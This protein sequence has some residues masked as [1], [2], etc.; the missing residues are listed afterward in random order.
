MVAREGCSPRFTERYAKDFVSEQRLSQDGDHVLALGKLAGLLIQY[1]T[2]DPAG[3][4]FFD[5]FPSA[6]YNEAGARVFERSFVCPSASIQFFRHSRR[7]VVVDGCFLSGLLKGVLL[8]ATV[9][10]AANR[11]QLI[12]FA[13]VGTE[14]A[15][16]WAF[17]FWALRRALG[18]I[19]DIVCDLDK[20]IMSDGAQQQLDGTRFR[21]CALHALRNLRSDVPGAGGSIVEKYFLALAGAPTAESYSHYMTKLLCAT[22]PNDRLQHW[23]GQRARLFSTIQIGSMMLGELTSNSAE[24]SNSAIKESRG[25]TCLDLTTSLMSVMEDK[26]YEQQLSSRS[27]ALEVCTVSLD[28]MV[29][30][31]DRHK[32]GK[33]AAKVVESIHVPGGVEVRVKVH[34]G[35]IAFR[36][37][38]N[39]AEQTYEGRL[40]WIQP[41]RLPL[42]SRWTG[43]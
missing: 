39:T 7:V 15:G 10:N 42:F 13:I 3:T 38:L 1:R 30:L 26:Y 41:A 18:P 24:Q 25:K 40:R 21:W 5:A 22:G 29:E 11:L 23:I 34:S 14:N 37:V 36:V 19:P 27:C 12:A 33:W 9:K 20:G 16:A 17:F 4:Y 31:R 2:G 28:A 35:A 6:E 8:T 32:N 43:A